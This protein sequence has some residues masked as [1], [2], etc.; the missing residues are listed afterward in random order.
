MALRFTQ[1][2]EFNDLFE[3]APPLVGIF[4][5][6]LEEGI[7]SLFIPY[8]HGCIGALE[9]QISTR[10]SLR[11]GAFHVLNRAIDSPITTSLFIE[12]L[13]SWIDHHN[14]RIAPDSGIRCQQALSERLGILSL[15]EQFDS[16]P[17]W[18]QYGD[19]HRGFVLE[20]NSDTSF[21]H[22]QHI[23]AVGTVQ[24]VRY[25]ESRQALVTYD[26][27]GSFWSVFN[28]L[29]TDAL[30]TKSDQWQHEREWRLV[31]PLNRSKKFPHTVAGSLHLFPLPPDALRAVILGARATEHTIDS[32]TCALADRPELSH[33]VIRRVRPSNTLYRLE[34]E[35]LNRVAK[36]PP[37]SA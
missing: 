19:C 6:G 24:K 22:R 12:Y 28:N 18:S 33:V 1:A 5:P 7:L 35:S 32:I 34:L 4:P 31:Y 25:V 17:L 37:N 11:P 29:L 23:G 8:V 16:L 9:R 30:L 20:L 26:P 3:L 36:A 21:F 15:S 14:S 27:T 10:L 2:S 13:K